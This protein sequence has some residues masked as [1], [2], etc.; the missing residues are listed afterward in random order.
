MVKANPKANSGSECSADR[1]GATE[2]NDKQAERE[3]AA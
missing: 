1:K 2:Q 3:R